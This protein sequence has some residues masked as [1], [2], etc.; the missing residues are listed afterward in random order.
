MQD[1]LHVLQNLWNGLT[2]PRRISIIASALAVVV[3]LG[4]VAFFASRPKF[5]LL[6][7]GLNQQDAAAIVQQL[8]EKNIPYELSSGGSTIM[9]PSAH[10]HKFRLE[11][12]AQGIPRMPDGGTGVGFELFDKPAFGMSDFMQKANYYR[13]LQGE[14]AR[15]IRQMDGVQDARVMLHV[16]EERLFTRDRRESKASVFLKTPGNMQLQPAQIKAIQYLVANGVEGLQPSRVA[17]VDSSGNALAEDMSDNT[18]ASLNRTQQQ[19]VRE[20]EDRLNGKA[21][22]MLDRVIGP[23]QAVV[24]LNADLNFDSIQETAEQFDPKS[25]VVRSETISNENNNSRS[26]QQPGGAAGSPTNTGSNVGNSGSPLTASEESRENITNTY[27]INRVVSTRQRATGEIR[28]LTVAVFVNKR[29]SGVGEQRK[30]TDRSPEE[31]K[32]LE[33]VVREAV[34][35]TDARK[36]SIKVQEVEF[37]DIFA[38]GT[39][40]AEVMGT[41]NRW[42]PY[43][44][45]G[46]LGILAIGILVYFW[47]I[48]RSSEKVADVDADFSDLLGRYEQFRPSTRRAREESEREAEERET[49]EGTREPTLGQTAHDIRMRTT[50]SIEDVG[51]LIAE[52]PVN[53]AQA[54]RQWLTKN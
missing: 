44:S 53:T 2:W 43:A 46:L 1:I 20:V 47:S 51:K 21:Q 22:T 37:A 25:S 31:I 9:V 33:E 45:Q 42:M 39:P 18:F 17:V 3:G 8:D 36:D 30:V 11:M 4:S 35:F 40:P 5:G 23:G 49:A 6:Y 54:F 48:V 19:F 50:L 16:P 34:G 10:V 15:T 32:M 13:A 52:N 24:R 38:E 26:Q 28:R 7:S 14:L 41:M 27:E 12:A 29:V